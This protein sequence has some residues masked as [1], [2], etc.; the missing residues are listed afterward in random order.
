MDIILF[1]LTLRYWNMEYSPTEDWLPELLGT[2]SM[3]PSVERLRK[4]ALFSLQKSQESDSAV[5]A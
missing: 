5:V 4:P 1:C 3:Q 2:Q